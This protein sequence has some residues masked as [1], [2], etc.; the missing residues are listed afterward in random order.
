M[1]QQLINKPHVNISVKDLEPLVCADCGSMDFV[2]MVRLYYVSPL[3]SPNGQPANVH[4]PAGFSCFVCGS[5][6]EPIRKSIFDKSQ[7]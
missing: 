4:T 7:G 6:I 5:A 3:Q 2:P 1:A